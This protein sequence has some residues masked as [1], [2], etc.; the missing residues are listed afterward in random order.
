MISPLQ[1]LSTAA[2][3][4]I[5]VVVSWAE[6][7]GITLDQVAAEVR[8]QLHGRDAGISAAPR[9]SHPICPSCAAGALV[10]C[11]KTTAM[12]GATVL[13][14]SRNCGYSRIVGGR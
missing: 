14:C 7:K 8:A 3:A 9:N 4:H 1:L 5:E 13:T 2:L 6:A 11:S 12:V 10:V